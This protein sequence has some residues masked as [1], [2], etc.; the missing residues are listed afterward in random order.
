MT[1]E[2]FYAFYKPN[3]ASVIGADVAIVENASRLVPRNVFEDDYQKLVDTLFNVKATVR[4]Q[5][6]FKLFSVLQILP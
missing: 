5:C 3:Y 6:V 1:F 4:W 2:S